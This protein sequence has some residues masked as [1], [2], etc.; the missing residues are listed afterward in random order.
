M[1]APKSSVALIGGGVYPASRRARSKRLVSTTNDENA[2]TNL[3]FCFLKF[4][5]VPAAGIT[6][7]EPNPQ[8]R[9]TRCSKRKT[10]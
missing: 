8:K 6:P 10:R 1:N 4:E 9:A 7:P 5:P 3:F 2:K